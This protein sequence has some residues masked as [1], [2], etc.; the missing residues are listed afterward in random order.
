MHGPSDKQ[1]YF[2]YVEFATSEAKATHNEVD[3]HVHLRVYAQ[4][5]PI[6]CDRQSRELVNIISTDSSL[7]KGEEGR[8]CVGQ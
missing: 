6:S 3:I 8:Q 2:V 4:S 1:T 7:R 5:R